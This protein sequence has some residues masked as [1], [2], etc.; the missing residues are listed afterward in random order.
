MPVPYQPAPQMVAAL[1]GKNF[2]EMDLIGRYGGEEFCIV[3][4]DISL[5]RAAVIANRVREVI[6]ADDS[7]GIRITM[8][9]GLSSLQFKA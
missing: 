4:P 1:L 5:E 3:L 9:F 8:S 6:Q 7:T 2:R